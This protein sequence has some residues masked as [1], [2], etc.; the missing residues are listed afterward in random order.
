MRKATKGILGAGALAAVAYAVWRAFESRRA[1][2]GV[3]WQPQPFPYPPMPRGPADAP[4]RSGAADPSPPPGPSWVE[5]A[6]DACPATHP[7]KAKLASGI[8]HV[9]GSANYERTRADRCYPS[10]VA[11]EAD[12]LRASKV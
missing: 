4:Q 8:F 2:T 10:A 9:P 5:P 1:E 12:G 7:V 6:G 3:T 11:A